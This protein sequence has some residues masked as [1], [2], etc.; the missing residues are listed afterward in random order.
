M[1]DYNSWV[2][3]RQQKIVPTH[4]SETVGYSPSMSTPYYRTMQTSSFGHSV[5]ALDKVLK[6]AQDA[7]L[8]VSAV[9]SSDADL[10]EADDPNILKIV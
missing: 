9:S 3:L 6:E 7:T 2:F 5:E 10:R 8:Y 1:S 4:K